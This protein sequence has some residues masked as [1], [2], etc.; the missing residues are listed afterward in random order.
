MPTPIFENT[1][2]STPAQYI[3]TLSALVDLRKKAAESAAVERRTKQRLDD[4][5]AEIA[6]CYHLARRAVSVDN[7]QEAQRLMSMRTQLEYNRRELEREYDAARVMTER[8]HDEC[9]ELAE[10]VEICRKQAYGD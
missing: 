7:M 1:S 6:Q 3:V 10:S 5:T 2:T 4:N 8:L 9:D